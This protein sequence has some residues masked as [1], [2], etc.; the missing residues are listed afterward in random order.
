M[1]DPIINITR[2]EVCGHC[3][4]PSLHLY[5]VKRLHIAGYKWDVEHACLFCLSQNGTGHFDR[6]HFANILMDKQLEL[7]SKLDQILEKLGNK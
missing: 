5:K 1:D 3:D 2:E 4:Y 7:E 6:P